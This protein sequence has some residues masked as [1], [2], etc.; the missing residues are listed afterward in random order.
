MYNTI[1]IGGGLLGISTAYHLVREDVEVLLIDR[2]DVGRATDAGAGIIS[3]ETSWRESPE[4]FNFATKAVAHY[5]VLLQYLYADDLHETGYA[6]CGLLLVAISDD[7]LGDFEDAK[8]RILDRQRG[9]ENVSEIGPREI[10]PAEAR[11]MFPPLGHVSRALY[12]RDAARVNGRDLTQTLYCGAKRHGLIVKRGTVSRLAINGRQIEG[13]YIGSDKVAAR[14]V[15]IACGAWSSS[16]EKELNV[17]IPVKPQRGQIIHLNLPTAQTSNW[18]IVDG[19]RSGGYYLVPWPKGHVVAGATRESDAAFSADLTANGVCTV[20]TEALRLAPG[21]RNARIREMRVGLRPLS[22]DG[23]PLLGPAPGIEG[24][25]FATGNGGTGLQLGPYS[26]K[27][28][29]E[30]ILGRQPEVNLAAF[31]VSRFD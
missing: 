10:S 11:E 29:S 26:G 25:Y 5:Q 21:L 18:P 23:L 22:G 12:Y 2:A 31:R 30:M 8:K 28:I 17:R 14:N 13:V 4:W 20:L 3:P 27:V 24:L 15:V 1:V 19:I 16:F 7:E 6:R 9:R